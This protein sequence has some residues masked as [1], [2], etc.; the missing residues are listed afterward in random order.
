MPVLCCLYCSFFFTY[1]LP[2]VWKGFFFPLFNT[3][4]SWYMFLTQQLWFELEVLLGQGKLWWILNDGF[5]KMCPMNC[6]SFECSETTAA[7]IK[8]RGRREWGGICSKNIY[9][10]ACVVQHNC[11]KQNE[12]TDVKVGTGLG[13][14]LPS[15]RKLDV[16]FCAGSLNFPSETTHLTCFSISCEMRWIRT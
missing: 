1:F 6:R 3:V 2:G 13:I 10:S 11:H 16:C 15:V 8:K 4:L 9:A 12:G 5:V 7:S 14:T